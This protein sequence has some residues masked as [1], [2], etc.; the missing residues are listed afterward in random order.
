MD[1][2]TTKYRDG[3]ERHSRR[4]L[5]RFST[6]SKGEKSRPDS[7]LVSSEERLVIPAGSRKEALVQLAL[8][9]WRVGHLDPKTL[10]QVRGRDVDEAGLQRALYRS[11]VI[12]MEHILG[13]I[14]KGRKVV[15]K[16]RLA[17]TGRSTLERLGAEVEELRLED[18]KHYVDM[19]PVVFVF[20]AIAMAVRYISLGLDDQ[21]LYILAGISFALMY[22]LRPFFFKL[23]RPKD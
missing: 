5:S 22:G 16:G 17:G 9:A 14:V 12:E 21:S 7:S 6:G 11:S 13:P 4:G 10:G 18:E 15:V 2:D 3:E 20:A 8:E 1:F 23:Q 19:T